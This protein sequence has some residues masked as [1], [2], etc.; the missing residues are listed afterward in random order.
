MH[1]LSGEGQYESTRHKSSVLHA[2]VQ[3]GLCPD[4]CEGCWELAVPAPMWIWGVLECECLLQLGVETV[5]ICLWCNSVSNKTERNAVGCLRCCTGGCSCWLRSSSSSSHALLAAI[6]ACS[7]RTAAL[8]CWRASVA[9]QQHH[10]RSLPALSFASLCCSCCMGFCAGVFAALVGGRL[11]LL[12]HVAGLSIP[13]DN[14]FLYLRL[15]GNMQLLHCTCTVRMAHGTVHQHVSSS[16]VA[17]QAML[18]IGG[19]RQPH[20]VLDECSNSSQLASHVAP[21][22]PLAARTAPRRQHAGPT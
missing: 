22:A 15:A 1:S 18:C 11:K 12:L 19:R 16:L 3:P 14:F 6:R 9:H 13:L 21:A 7:C 17:A 2:Q 8:P 10:R 4:L 20:T 5:L